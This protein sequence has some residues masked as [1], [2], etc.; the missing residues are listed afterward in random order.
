MTIQL[1]AFEVHEVFVKKHKHAFSILLYCDW[2][3]SGWTIG[4]IQNN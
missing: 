3:M 1:L 2:K 4:N